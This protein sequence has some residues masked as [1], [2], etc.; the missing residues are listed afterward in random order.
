M[1]LIAKKTFSTRDADIT[2]V[3]FDLA[4]P[5]WCAD[6]WSALSECDWLVG[7]QNVARQ[8]FFLSETARPAELMSVVEDV[9]G[10]PTPVTTCVH[11]PPADG[12]AVS[13]ELWAFSSAA[14]LRHG[15]HVTWA[16]TP[17]ATW[18]FVG[19]MT[20][21]DDEPPGDGVRRL[22]RDAQ[23]ELHAAG[24]PFARMVRTWYY[25]G[26][27]L[28]P[29]EH[30][31]RYAEFNAARNESY[32]DMWTDLCLSPASTGI[33]MSSD[34]IAFEGL[35]LNPR[36]DRATVAWI[37]NPLQTSPHLYEGQGDRRS[38]P[39]FSRAAAV[40]F[41]DAALLF[42]SGTASIRD[43]DVIHRDDVVA[44]TETTIENIA[45]LI[46]G[47]SLD[48]LQQLRVYIKRRQ[49]TD[50][51]RDCC[52]AHFPDVPCVCL[53]ADVCRPQCLVEIEG[54]HAS[55]APVCASDST[56][57]S[58]VRFGRESAENEDFC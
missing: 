30:G 51:V 34:R 3:N 25:I 57:A 2:F 6:L 45:A 41:D 24:L 36:H 42:V 50:L 55:P 47:G 32:R 18:G 46:D 1:E 8:T 23:R 43:S 17:S 35:V 13:C 19:G 4:G 22:L 7:L 14:P 29:G 33:G 58:A 27:I 20:T 12:S 38:N 40:N 44:Q 31:S 15:R 54:V 56:T 5:D 39:A 28:A 26:D 53:I 52:R 9:Y 48:G 11:Q 16:S 37:D 49:D 21:A 10:R